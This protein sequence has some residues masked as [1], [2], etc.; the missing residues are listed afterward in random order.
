LNRLFRAE[1]HAHQGMTHFVVRDDGFFLRVNQFIFLF[2]T[3]NDAL[4]G[5]DK[6]LHGDT[7]GTASSSKQS[8]F[9]NQIRQVGATKS[10]G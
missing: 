8:R 10:C 6:I 3:G 4:N 9:V 1:R 5:I 7:V 2:Q